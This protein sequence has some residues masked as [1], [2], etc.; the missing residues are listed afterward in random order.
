MATEVKGEFQALGKDVRSAQRQLDTF[1]APDITEV[2]LV[3]H[4]VTSLCPV[5]GQP[6]FATVTVTYTPQERCVET[7][8][9]KLYLWTFRNEGHFAEQLAATI[10]DDL[11][12][13]LSP[14]KMEVLVEFTSRGGII[15]HAKSKYHQ[16]V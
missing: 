6:D 14:L 9:L 13:A 12:N 1:P 11:V 15:I 16:A 7:K 10:R 8:S 5:T 3:C 4:E 2:K